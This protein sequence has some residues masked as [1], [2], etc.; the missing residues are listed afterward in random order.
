MKQKLLL[1]FVLCLL[2]AGNTIAS[3]TDNGDGT[4]TEGFEGF[5]KSGSVWT[6]GEG[7]DYTGLASTWSI[8]TSSGS[9][10][11]SSP[12]I[13]C[14]SNSNKSNYLITP[15]LQ[16]NLIFWMKSYGK[17]YDSSVSA[18]ECTYVN[19]V[20]TLG[21]K[22][23]EVT[24]P[25]ADPVADF[26]QKTI[27]YSGHG[28]V[29]L[30]INYAYIDDFTY[31]PYGPKGL[32]VSEK[33]DN[34]VTLS[35]TYEG[36]DQSAWQV[37]YS[38]DQNFG[39][40]TI[41]DANNTTCKI[42]GLTDNVDY[43]AKVRTN[44][45]GAGFSEWTDAITMIPRVEKTINESATNSSASIPIVNR[46]YNAEGLMQTQFII[47]S[48]ELVPDF[49]GKTLTQLVFYTSQSTVN[50]T[51]A[52]FEVYLNTT[53]NSIYSA[54]SLE[55]FE[56]WG[57]KVF[58]SGA[59]SISNNKM[60]IDIE[61]FVYLGKNLMIGFKQTN[62]TTSSSPVSISWFGKTQY[63]NYSGIY[64]G[65]GYNDVVSTN[66]VN[67]IPKVSIITS[68]QFVPVTIGSTGYTTFSCGR[69]LDLST[70]PEGLTAFYV[71]E[72]GVDKGNS[73]VRLTPATSVVSAGTGLIMKGTA[74]SS[75]N[76]P[77]ATTSGSELIGN[78]MVGCVDKTTISTNAS[79]Y[80]LVNNGGN[81]VF[82]SL[83]EN[84]ATI[85]AGKAYLQAVAGARNLS[86]VFDEEDSTT[87]ICGIRS[88]KDDVKGS[89]FDLQ[90]RKVAHPTKGFYII[91]GRKVVK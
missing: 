2:S 67:F 17:T 80:V 71:V 58:G 13:Y 53:D 10:H 23:G 9:Y 27:E 83:A 86:I 36:A 43:Y 75:Y 19:G 24:I 30:L 70:L 7:W 77:T 54:S 81:P 48:S 51:G 41:I 39:S 66:R 25:K 44:Y 59:L 55:A 33:T 60:V 56:P 40:G 78:L 1:F 69:A 46:L 32:A 49:V 73:V 4:V 82:Q 79:R 47:P 29:A 88:K 62:K 84:G 31:S 26:A 35:W 91:N 57:T 37:A 3:T 61:P 38:T 34:T 18:Y 14:Y 28:R 16:N 8:S 20:F 65:T 64:Y 74:G 68:A 22:I 90:G 12:S 5:S 85:P 50:L 45:G 72:D 6:M 15:D 21:E 63:S 52:T 76:I 87:D 42:S 89:I 11:S